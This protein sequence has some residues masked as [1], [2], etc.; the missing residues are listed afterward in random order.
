M[1]ITITWTRR[2]VGCLFHARTTARGSAVQRSRIDATARPLLADRRLA[3]T[4]AF[5]PGAPGAPA[6]INCDI[7]FK[8]KT[9]LDNKRPMM[10]IQ[11]TECARATCRS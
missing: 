3:R 4:P 11:R 8:K 2:T 7:T 6:T 1:V 5:R 10:N 9:Q